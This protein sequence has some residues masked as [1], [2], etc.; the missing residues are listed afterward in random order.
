MYNLDV[1]K[2]MTYSEVQR[3]MYEL[4]VTVATLN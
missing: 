3:R 1:K 2:Y 4:V